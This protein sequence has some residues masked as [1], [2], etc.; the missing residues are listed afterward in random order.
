MGA[1]NLDIRIEN[2]TV[3]GQISAAV[4]TYREGLTQITKENCEE[5]SN[6]TQTPAPPVNN[7]V[8]V[9]V[10]EG[11]VWNVTGPCWLT[12]L[13]ILAGGTVAGAHGKTLTMTV[14]GVKKEVA[15]GE[16]TGLI[17]LTIA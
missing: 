2:A 6:I 11:G 5:L 17:Y 14:D 12:R 16:Y 13:T 7:G 1:K 9:T 3:N 15:P 8:I 4:A 10:A